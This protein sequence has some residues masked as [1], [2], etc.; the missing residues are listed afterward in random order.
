LY[1]H[2]EG[3][4]HPS[5]FNF[6]KAFDP[7]IIIVFGGLG[8]LTGTIVASF[9]WGLLLFYVLPQVLSSN[10]MQWRY[11]IY[12]LALLL[13]MLLRQQGLLGGSEW[14]FLKPRRWPRA[15]PSTSLPARPPADSSQAAADHSEV[16]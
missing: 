12:P 1:A 5:T 3:F 16:N 14:G 11:V 9:T 13:I 4:L 8:S 7:L 2:Q 6:V 10:S 15:Q